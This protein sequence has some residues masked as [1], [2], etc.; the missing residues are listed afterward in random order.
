MN[1]RSSVKYLTRVSIT[2]LKMGKDFFS[3][4]I[5]CG[6]GDKTHRL[7]CGV[8]SSP[9]GPCGLAKETNV[10]PSLLPGLTNVPPMI[11]LIHELVLLEWLSRSDPGILTYPDYATGSCG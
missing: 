1:Q 9:G 8:V 2:L 5:D 6:P 10:L 7:L 4:R 11:A 3:R